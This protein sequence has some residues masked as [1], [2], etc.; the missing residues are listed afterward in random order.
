MGNTEM[1]IDEIIYKHRPY[2]EELL[3]SYDVLVDL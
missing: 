3:S 1:N 2:D